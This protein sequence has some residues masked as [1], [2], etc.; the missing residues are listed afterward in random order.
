MAEMAEKEDFKFDFDHYDDE[1]AYSPYGRWEEMRSKCP[2]AWSEKNGGYFILSKY[3]DISEA[4]RNTGTFSSAGGVTIPP[5]PVPKLPPN[6]FDPPVHGMYRRIVNP[7]FSPERVAENRPWMRAIARDYTQRMLKQDAFDVSID[8]AMQVTQDVTQRLLGIVDAPDDMKRCAE[9]LVLM[10]GNAEESGAKLVE[11]LNL[12]IDKRRTAPGDDVI[13]TLLSASYDG[14]RPLTD[15]E[16]VHTSLLI[17]LAGLDTTTSAIG[18]AVW[19]MLKHPEIREQLLGADQRTWR[20]AL[21]EFVRWTSPAQGTARTLAHETEVN[22]CPMHSG[23]R[24]FFLVASGNRDEEEFPNPDEIVIDRF[25]NRHLAFGMGPH[26]CLGSHV[27]KAIL[28]DV[29]EG[30]LEGLHNFRIKSDDDVVWEA[31]NVRGI[32]SLP[33]VRI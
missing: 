15:H 24:I 26:R 3:N 1:S 16:I 30:L 23:E 5:K 9:D 25:P 2:V 21:D 11:L 22:G 27:A 8:C 6:E 20:L 13:S 18:G 12:E 4:I 7:L 33:V 31:S 17:L 10:R 29:L 32:R 28:Q 19:Y 14:K